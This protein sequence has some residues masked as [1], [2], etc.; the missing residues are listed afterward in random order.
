[1]TIGKTSQALPRNL[2]DVDAQFMTDLLRSQ[3][4][5]S[6][7][8]FITKVVESD[9]GMTA[10]YFSAIKRMKCSYNE[11]TD[12]PD[13][14]IIK[15]W[16]E[17]ELA[18]GE[19]IAGMFAK[20][21]KGYM[22]DSDQFYPRPKA[23]LAAFDEEKDLW[24][25]VMEDAC[26][27]A[28]QKLHEDE[29]GVDDVMRMIPKLVDVAITWEGCDKGDKNATLV[30]AGAH[31]WTAEE[32]LSSFRHLMPGGAKL[33]DYILSN[34]DSDLVPANWRQTLGSDFIATFARKMDA[35]YADAM[36]TNGATCTLSH[37]DLRGDN[38]FFCE[39]S[40]THPDGWLT[41]DFQLMFQG[42]VPSDLA[43]LMNSGSVLPEVYS[44]E[45]KERIMR[46]FYDAFM[47]RTK[48]YPDY[49]WKQFQTEY[50]IMASVLFIFYTSF[51]AAILQAGLDNEQP[52]RIELGDRGETEADLAPD[53]VRKRMWW[54]KAWANFHST[55]TDFD[56]YNRLKTMP[57][58]TS[59]M[60][61][62]FE[63][64]EKIRNR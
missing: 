33:W 48:A 46:T 35:W 44:G 23:F 15:A 58:N 16:P 6:S 41:I 12:A 4:I 51:G 18:P 22:M 60:G 21:I 2:T 24:A 38:L 63:V 13:S 62:W 11:P 37:G 40:D 27:F 49:T 59:E 45:N 1:M 19:D 53:E 9:V 64:P 56:A 3:D 20:D 5:I 43:Y 14:F 54:R 39:P 36:P 30:A 8:N 28:D 50:S 34:T 10:G 61:D 32:N 42:P 47:A 52:A 57:D 25:L 26:T 31:H 7:T 55:F 17:F 29:M